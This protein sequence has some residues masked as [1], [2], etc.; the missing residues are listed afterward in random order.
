MQFCIDV[1]SVPSQLR[2]HDGVLHASAIAITSDAAAAAAAIMED[3]AAKAQA[4]ARQAA[5]DAQAAVLKAQCSTIE[6]AGH[7]LQTLQQRHAALLD[8]TQRIVVDL[9]QA[10]FERLVG[11]LTPRE[12]VAAVLRLLLVEAPPKLVSPMLRVHPD[13]IALLPE[14]G[15]ELKADP[16]MPRGCCRLEADSGEW[17]VSFDAA[18]AALKSAFIKAVAAPTTGGE[19]ER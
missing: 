2:P 6:Q 7:L 14:I 18:V 15:W 17:S 11:E 12:R 1:V 13:D 10:L 5:A 3:A 19:A 8:G 16:G 9:A 4:L